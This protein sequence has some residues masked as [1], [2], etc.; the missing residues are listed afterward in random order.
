[1]ADD[2]NDPFKLFRD[3]WKPMEMPATSMPP[4]F[5]L[6]EIEKKIN[7]LRVIEG[8]LTVNLNMLQMTIKTL[9]VQR[10][11]LQT[12]QQAAKQNDSKP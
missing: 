5:S 7:E 4:M 9:D 3:M 1:M 8:W 12:L 2:M 6:E 11:A 10:S